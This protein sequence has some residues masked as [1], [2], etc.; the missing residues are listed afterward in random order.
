VA[1]YYHFNEG[2]GRVV[3]GQ[4]RIEYC[5][6]ALD[7]PG[8]NRPF[9]FHFD[10]G[11][12]ALIENDFWSLEQGVCQTVIQELGDPSS[13]L[14]AFFSVDRIPGADWVYPERGLSLCVMP[15]TGLIAR[16]TAYRPSTLD[17][18]RRAIRLV[19]PAREFELG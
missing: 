2:A 10:D 14:D 17:H 1:R 8:F 9:L 11:K 12:L 13:R 16:W 3:R 18:Y 5:F 7:R 15:Q 4:E 19:S 6:R